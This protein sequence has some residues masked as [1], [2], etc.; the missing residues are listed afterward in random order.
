MEIKISK[1]MEKT[2]FCIATAMRE[3]AAIK[4]VLPYPKRKELMELA[5]AEESLYMEMELSDEQRKIIDHILEMR[6]EVS[7]IDLTMTYL[8]G[9]LDSI[10]F[11]RN[12]GFLDTILPVDIS[13][14]AEN[15]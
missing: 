3:Q 11:L 7:Q 4:Y 9:M 2:M 8:A 14:S 10:E 5:C 6:E 12:G 1:K 15:K 13:E